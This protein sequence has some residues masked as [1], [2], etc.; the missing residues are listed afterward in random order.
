MK[1]KLPEDDQDNSELIPLKKAR[2]NKK[3]E[4]LNDSDRL[5]L[6]KNNQGG[7]SSSLH[8]SS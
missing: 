5:G 8:F 1:N 7:S 3:S 4:D 2:N 6:F